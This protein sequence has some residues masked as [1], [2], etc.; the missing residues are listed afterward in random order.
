MRRALLLMLPLW[1]AA[2][3]PGP[4]PDST[5]P[6][7]TVINGEREAAWLVHSASLAPVNSWQLSGRL[8]VQR[9]GEGWS[10][11]VE[12]NQLD[13]SYRIH[14]SGPM[15][16]GGILLEGDDEL[17]SFSDGE[18]Y[19]NSSRD[20]E[21]LLERELGWRMPISALRYWVRGLP[22]PRTAVERRVLDGQGRLLELEQS[23]W[24][25]L[26]PRYREVGALYLPTKLLLFSQQG[27]VR[28]VVGRWEVEQAW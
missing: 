12:W 5:L 7:P 27:E 18:G 20:P 22:D 16:Q 11:G 10:A 14:L 13:G 21:A 8:G 4:R 1:L 23:G 26:I 15:G 2:C 25:V 17:V 24:K 6:D 28:L 19:Y 3:T 9:G